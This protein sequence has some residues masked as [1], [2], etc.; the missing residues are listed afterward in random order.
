MSERAKSIVLVAFAS[1]EEGVGKAT[2]DALRFALR[3]LAIEG[4]VHTQSKRYMRQDETLEEAVKA[5]DVITANDYG[6]LRDLGLEPER[7][8]LRVT[9]EHGA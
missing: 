6:R 2:E 1:A 3:G 7:L 9:T 4:T 8:G 5:E